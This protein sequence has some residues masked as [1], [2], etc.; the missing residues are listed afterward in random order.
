MSLWCFCQPVLVVE[1]KTG[2]S[3]ISAYSHSNDDVTFTDHS[4][5][6]EAQEDKLIYFW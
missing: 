3:Q 1:G 5:L 4:V 6:S 2:S